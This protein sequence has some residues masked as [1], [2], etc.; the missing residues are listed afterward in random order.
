[1]SSEFLVGTVMSENEYKLC[2]QCGHIFHDALVCPKCG[3]EIN[4]LQYLK[5]RD[6]SNQAVYYGYYYRT[7]YEK[8]YKEN[9]E[10]K[11]K[12]SLIQPEN[13]IELLAI[14]A[15]SGIVGGITKPNITA[16]K[17]N[18]PGGPLTSI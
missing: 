1:M 3:H 14:A 13:Y 15:L 6:Y 8:Q 12:F 10:I 2:L 9:R 16:S 17:S 5:L 7:L 4:A 18:P 11:V